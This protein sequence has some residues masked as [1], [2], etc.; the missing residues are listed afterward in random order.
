MNMVAKLFKTRK[1][2]EEYISENYPEVKEGKYTLRST[3]VDDR[4]NIDVVDMPNLCWS[5]E[6]P[7]CGVEDEDFNII[8]TVAWWEEGDDK[9]ELFVGNKQTA[10]F[11]S[12]YDA[13]EAYSKAV[14]EEGH[15]DDDEEEVFEV[16][17][18][19]NGEDIS[20]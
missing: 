8:E 13:R 2:A 3:S 16:K 19:C 10:T 15:K 5:G 14:E 4:S 20:N 11:D 17:L 6:I 18:F 1:L 9:Y 7:A 12:N